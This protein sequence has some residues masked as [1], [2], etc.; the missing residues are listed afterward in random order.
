[1]PRSSRLRVGFTLVE[2][3]VVIAIIGVLVA[4]L[5]PAVQSAREAAR[6]IQCS[7]NLKQLGLGIHN[8]HDTTLKFPPSHLGGEAGTSYSSGTFFCIIL[9]FIEQT[10]LGEKFDNTTSY[11]LSTNPTAGALPG[12]SLKTFQCPTRG[13]SGGKMSDANPQVGATGDY[14]ICSIGISDFQWQHQSAEDKLYGMIIGAASKTNGMNYQPRLAM[15]DVTDGLSNTACIG[16]KHV[17]K[18]DMYKG[19][20]AGGSADGSIYLTQQVAWYECHTVR[21]MAHPAGLSRGSQDNFSSER[22]KMFGSWHPATVLFLMGDGAVR[23]IRQTISLT[24]LRQLGDRR[25]GEVI[26]EDY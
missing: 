23:N 14:A 7:N 8:F 19:G 17:Y 1:M 26:T 11:N 21:N 20:D 15:R 24:T 2:L 18:L 5:L 16:E 4:L 10:A 22:H 25:D 9:P 6:R 3:L 13:R 12:A